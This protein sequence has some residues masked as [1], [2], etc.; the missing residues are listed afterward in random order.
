MGNK[1][2]ESLFRKAVEGDSEA[3]WELIKP[4]SGLIFSVA[5]GI[6][7]DSD[8][9]KDILQEVYLEAFR[10]LGTLR[11]PKSIHSW[12]Y[13]LTKNLTHNMIRKE[14]QA[15][16]GIAELFENR[17]KILP[18]DEILSR[19]KDMKRLDNAIDTLP[20]HFRE[21][22]SMKYMNLYSCREISEILNITVEAVKSR[23]FEARKLLRQ[24]IM[25]LGETSRVNGG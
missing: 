23:L 9:A 7:K 5:F 6:L 20:E 24:K 21:I 15:R 10:S 14:T 13:S 18:I 11:D 8:Q 17:P 16:K 4:Y 25:K 1:T 2:K 19:E 12:L 3:Y 22:L